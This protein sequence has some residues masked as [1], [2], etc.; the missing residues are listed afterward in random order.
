MVK[1]LSNS[2]IFALVLLSTSIVFLGCEKK[3]EQT[4]QPKDG[5]QTEQTAPDTVSEIKEPVVEEK[6]TIPDIKGTWTGVFDKRATTL[7]ITEQ[8]DSSF[9]GA[10]TI[11][12]RE[13][14]NQA[15]KGTFSP[16]T[17]KMTMTDQL[18][19]RYQ[20]SYSGKLSKEL[21]NYSGTFTMKLDGSKFSFN[22]N[23][24]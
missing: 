23:K 12:Y 5:I 19:S 14:I 21:N 4:E 24:K 22:L 17:L 18:H 9:S 15:V 13:V 10:I 11:N 3:T 1:L 2:K 20:G 6:I 8:A 7:K 16:T